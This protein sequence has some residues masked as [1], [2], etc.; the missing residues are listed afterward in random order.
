MKPLAFSLQENIH[1]LKHA[2]R[3]FYSQK[4]SVSSEHPYK[5]LFVSTPFD[6]FSFSQNP[7]NF[8]LR[9]LLNDE[10]YSDA[11][12]G[13][14]FLYAGNEGDILDFYEN[15][16][17][18][19][20]WAQ[21]FKGLAVFCEHRY[22]GKSKL[23]ENKD[24]RWLTSEQSLM[25]YVYCLND[26]RKTYKK[27]SKVIVLGGS[28]GGMQAFSFLR[29]YPSQVAG[30]IASSAPV[31]QFTDFV[32][33]YKFMKVVSDDFA[34]YGDWCK[35]A[36][37]SGYD[38]IDQYVRDGKLNDLGS[39]FKT[40]KPLK[41]S[42]IILLK[43]FIQ[44]SA[45]YLAMLNYATATS[46]L[47]P[48]PAWPIKETCNR[49]SDSLNKT[50][51]SVRFLNSQ[52]DVLQ[53]YFNSTGKETCFDVTLAGE[54]NTQEEND[55]GFDLWNFQACTEMIMPI[56]SNGVTDMFHSDPWN[57]E[58]YLNY[59]RTTL[60]VEPKPYQ[61][62]ERY[63]PQDVETYNNVFYSNGK[64]DPWS[65]GGVYSDSNPKVVPHFIEEGAHH[66]ELRGTTPSDPN[67]V[68][69]ARKMESYAIESW[70]K[71]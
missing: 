70:L 12:G 69:F 56:G 10:Y 71:Q 14:I 9:Y 64:F 48:L 60:K 32:D 2:E 19:F 8:Q 26:V 33:P 21:Q 68:V 1:K 42:D 53:V 49:I 31:L 18:I 40:C 34:Y 7:Q 23:N 66:A 61:F 28:Y 44:N 57:L 58:D 20:E 25:D 4:K 47:R 24:L 13:P 5:T 29:K 65:A 3:K 59:C 35:N 54:S 6:H 30:A 62:M 17:V 51:D 67:S 27:A 22:Y 38:V 46:F 36:V 37:R 16:G 63:A 50:S 45:V 55:L 41:S 43:R 52:M 15:T 39:I 11:V